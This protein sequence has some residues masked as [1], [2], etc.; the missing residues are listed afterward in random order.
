MET[1]HLLLI[2]NLPRLHAH[3]A[4]APRL[5]EQLPVVN[6]SSFQVKFLTAAFVLV[7]ETVISVDQMEKDYLH[8]LT[9]A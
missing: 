1:S 7:V 6:A 9:F 8:R 5:N 3:T 2:L 4:F